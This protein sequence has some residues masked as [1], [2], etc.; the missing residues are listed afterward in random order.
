M[1]CVASRIDQEERVRIC[2]NRKKLMKRLMGYRKEFVD[3]QLSY[4]RSLRNTGATLSQLTESASFEQEEMDS[5]VGFPLSPQP[6][7]PCLLPPAPPPPPS[8]SPDLRDKQLEAESG[9]EEITEI[10]D[11]TDPSPPPP[12][13]GSSWEYWDLFGSVSSKHKDDDEDERWADTNCEFAA[14]GEEPMEDVEAPVPATALA[15]LLPAKQKIREPDDDSS[16]LSWPNKDNG[17]A[18]VVLWTGKKSLPAIIKRLDE[19]FLKASAVVE[20]MAVFIDMDTT[21]TSFHQS[22]K[23]NK[24]KRSNSAKVFSALS[25]SWSFRSLQSTRET[26]DLSGAC[27]PCKP[28]AHCLTLQKLYSE[29]QKLYKNIKEEEVAKMDYARKTSILQ[30]QEAESETVKAEKTRAAVETLEAYILSLQESIGR[31]CSNILMLMNEEL[32]PQLIALASGMMHM[33]QTMLKCHQAQSQISQQF[34]RQMDPSGIEPTTE[35][36]LQAACQLQ[37]EVA[38]WCQS[39]CSLV[40]FQREYAKALCE[41]SELTKDLQD[42]S[43]PPENRSSSLVHNLMQKW[44]QALD[45]LPDKIVSEAINSLL[46]A[47]N[48]VLTQQQQELETHKRYEKLGRRLERELTI[49]SELELKFASTLCVE[50][51]TTSG[52]GKHPLKIRR[53]KV[54]SLKKLANDEK[55]RYTSSIKITRAMI[56]NNL[57]TSLPKVFQALVTYSSACVHNFESV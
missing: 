16:T 53:A 10:D 5:G 24:R 57:Q 40:K 12:L 4:L 17:D 15:K 37:T 23:E 49:L 56:L 54:E 14:E 34:N 48:C 22:I 26:G 28:G 29:E 46:S 3:A 21:G 33:W 9:G 38:Y 43:V 20:D 45:K 52:N 32:H 50:D 44:L 18:A 41:W 19:Y 39:F 11:E 31:C 1:G 55:I 8:F 13:P 25:W 6:S 51:E 36:R 7:S 47:I 27:E 30:R 35:Y 2:K 42:V